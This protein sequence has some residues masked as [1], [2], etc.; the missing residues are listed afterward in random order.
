MATEARKKKILATG[1]A[2]YIGS[3]C[4]IELIKDGYE[5]V[6]AD[7]FCNSCRECVARVEKIA[8][9]DK[10]EVVVC[11]VR[12]KSQVDALFEAHQFY[13]VLHLAALK[14]VGQ[15]TS[16]PLAY[17]KTNVDGTINVLQS[18]KEHNVKNFL[19]SSSATVYGMP[20]YLPLDEKHRQI[21]DEIT[22]PYGKSKYVVEHILKDLH[23]SDPAWNIVILR[24]FNPVG[25][26]ESGLIGEDPTGPPANLMPFVSQVAVGRRP[27]VQVFGSDYDTADGTGV[28]DYI[29]I[30][31]LARGHSLS[32]TKLGENPGLK[33][34]NLGTGKGYSVLEMVTAFEKAAGRK[35]PYKIVGR[36][37][38]DLASCYADPSFAKSE[39]GWVA[40]KGLDDMCRD[41]WN[42]QSNN[43]DGFKSV[44]TNNNHVDVKKST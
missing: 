37:P 4:I 43:P 5:V 12:D 33:I 42:W 40:E 38:G 28:R 41:L 20:Q 2:G 1:G 23:K 13:A 36:R 31:D 15:S 35:V 29:H 3:H 14:S 18:M 7:N 44:D 26:H 6:I 24:Y 27:E 9:V 8:G 16:E 21:G 19:F 22:N 32:V 10:I 17:Y 30:V 39:L 25:A 34:Y 11:D